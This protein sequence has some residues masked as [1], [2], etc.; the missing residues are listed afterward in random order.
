MLQQSHL[1][2]DCPEQVVVVPTMNRWDGSLPNLLTSL[3]KITEGSQDQ[4]RFILA[5]ATSL[6]ESAQIACRK[7][8]IEKLPKEM[9][10]ALF[11]VTPESQREVAAEVCR[12]TGI[13]PRLVNAWLTWTGYA[14]QRAKLDVIMRGY[15]QDGSVKVLSLDDDTT[16]PQVYR[17]LNV[18]DCDT[19]GSSGTNSQSVLRN[20]PD[21]SAFS[22]HDNSLD[23]FFQPLGQEVSPRYRASLLLNDSMHEALE[24]ARSN[25]SARFHVTAGEQ[26]DTLQGGTIV[27]A[28]ATKTGV[29]DY[30]TVRIAEASLY[31]RFPSTEVALTAYQDSPTEPFVF[32]AARTNIDSACL[33][34]WFTAKTAGFPW[35]F[36]SDVEISKSNPLQT[37][38]GHY[39][40]DNEIL[41]YLCEVIAQQTGTT[42]VYAGGI[43]T[44]VEHHRARSGYRPAMLE[45][46]T[47]SLVGNLAAVAATEHLTID[48]VSLLPTLR[49][50]ASDYCVPELRTQAVF[51]DIRHL[52]DV[53]LNMNKLVS[54][55][56]Q[57]AQTA[58]QVKEFNQ[59]ISRYQEVYTMLYLKTGGFD[60]PLF[61]SQIDK[62]IRSQ[63]VF[64]RG[65]L[66]VAP[67]IS[68]AV[69]GMLSQG[70]YPALGYPSR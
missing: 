27:A 67:R 21:L 66:E 19:A 14:S 33:S 59:L 58:H 17:R 11:L 48:P 7:E 25:G 29:P 24:T 13:N 10:E 68:E 9:K 55:E 1:P 28:M 54:L 41:P 37:V 38:T 44:H 34:R 32:Q 39:R 23:G 50:I 15:A 64:F 5:D 3:S 4:M 42:F 53:A 51:Q 30:R 12:R 52:A 43:D 70:R 22:H 16:I 61:K 60:F 47:A 69:Q 26:D 62:E 8:V 49:P 6:S 35:W 46:A 57:D 20:Q 45:Q 65:V 40:A 56:R 63:L 18:V 2:K 36:I 31:D